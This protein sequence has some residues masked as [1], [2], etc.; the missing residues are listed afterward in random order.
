MS[1]STMRR[2]LIAAGGVGLL[3]SVYEPALAG[4]MQRFVFP[5]QSNLN[6]AAPCPEGFVGRG[7]LVAVRGRPPVSDELRVAVKLRR[8]TD[9]LTSE[10]ANFAAVRVEVSVSVQGGPCQPHLS[11]AAPLR[12]GRFDH[13]FAGGETTPAIPSGPVL[14]RICGVKLFVDGASDPFGIDGIQLSL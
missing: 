10:P 5:L 6:C 9:R 3:L 7:Q 11:A 1:E 14:L 13:A 8:V 4:K 12:R 2:L